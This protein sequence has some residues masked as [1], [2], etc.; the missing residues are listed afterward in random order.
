MGTI[1][2][3]VT[4]KVDS[5]MAKQWLAWMQKTHI[6]DVL[7]TGCFLNATVFR[8]K[9]PR[10]DEGV[11][12]AVQY[13]CEDMKTLEKYHTHFA[14]PLQQDHS[15]RFAGK[16]AAFRTILEELRVVNA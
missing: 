8:L 10:E 16:F 9:Y 13:R 3:N 2:Y 15:E 12:F 11:T 7:A 6:P 1:L 14:G 5:D 4:V